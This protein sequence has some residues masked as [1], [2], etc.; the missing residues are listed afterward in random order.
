[1]EDSAVA[2][3]IKAGILPKKRRKGRADHKIFDSAIGET[4]CVAFAEALCSL[5]ESRLAVLRL[6]KTGKD[7]VPH[8]LPPIEGASSDRFELLRGR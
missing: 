1:M 5:P 8:E 3:L 7:S 6:A 2:R 4:G